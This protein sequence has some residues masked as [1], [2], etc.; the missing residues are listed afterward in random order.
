MLINVSQI[1]SATKILKKGE[2]TSS[3]IGSA[4]ECHLALEGYIELMISMGGKGSSS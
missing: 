4:E 1:V 3:W 2:I